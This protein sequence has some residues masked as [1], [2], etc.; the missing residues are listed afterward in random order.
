MQT[1]TPQFRNKHHLSLYRRANKPTSAPP[2]TP[3]PLTLADRHHAKLNTAQRQLRIRTALHEAA[4]LA[5]ALA[6][7]GSWHAAYIRVPKKSPKNGWKYR[8]TLG[9]VDA[10]HDDVFVQGCICLAG[11]VIESMQTDLREAYRQSRGDLHDFKNIR[12]PYPLSGPG[13]TPAIKFDELLEAAFASVVRYWAGID[14]IAAGMLALGRADGEVPPTQI[15]KLVD[16]FRS[17][18][19]ADRQPS[20]PAPEWDRVMRLTAVIATE[21][22]D[23]LL[24]MDTGTPN[25]EPDICPETAG[26]STYPNQL[27]SGAVRG[28]A[29]DSSGQS[30]YPNQLKSGVNWAVDEVCSGQSTYPNQ[31]KF[32]SRPRARCLSSGQSTYPNQLKYIA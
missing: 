25:M 15:G 24:P 5:V 4:H 20:E 30:T 26:Q 13:R 17:N 19:W 18:A 2:F 12:P 32:S 11:V 21:C 16:Y 31:L 9:A 14:G 29:A 23:V 6:Q 1:L 27:K 22:P 3:P 28:R 10:N 7:N 8:G